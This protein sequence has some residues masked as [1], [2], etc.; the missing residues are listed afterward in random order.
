MIPAAIVQVANDHAKTNWDGSNNNFS[1][2]LNLDGNPLNVTTNYWCSV[3]LTESQFA[4]AGQQIGWAV[5][6]YPDSEFTKPNEKLIELGL[7]RVKINT[8]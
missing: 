3:A 1:V 5:V 7:K 8:K 4:D 6:E 2:K